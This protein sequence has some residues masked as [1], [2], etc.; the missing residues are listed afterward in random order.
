[1]MSDNIWCFV[2]YKMFSQDTLLYSAAEPAQSFS[3]MQRKYSFVV[4]AEELWRGTRK[5]QRGFSTWG[6]RLKD[7]GKAVMMSPSSH[8]SCT[9]R[10]SLHTFLPWWLRAASVLL[11]I[12][13]SLAFASWETGSQRRR[14]GEAGP[15]ERW[16]SLWIQQLPLH[17][18]WGR[19]RLWMA[20]PH[21]LRLREFP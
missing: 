18:N 6:G 2:S 16:K 15:E 5:R 9:C 12:Y 14:R 3:G 7:C 11:S 1:M 10:S 8:P 13:V 17:A 20:N 21:L 4:L 19:S